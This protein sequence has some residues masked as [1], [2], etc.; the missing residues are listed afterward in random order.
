MLKE[1]KNIG[2]LEVGID[3]VGRGCLA[4]PV[5][6]GAVILPN[7]FNHKLIR[8]S[9]ALS[10]KQRDEAYELIIKNAIAYSVQASSVKIIDKTN[11]TEATFIAM[12]KCLDDLILTQG[13]DIKH[14]LVDGIV[15]NPYKNI[16]YSCIVKGDNTY[17]SIAAAAIIAKVE[18][19]NYMKKLH[20]IHPTYDF[21]S[22][23]GYGTATHIK[24]IKEHGL[25]Q[26]H[27]KLF[28]RNFI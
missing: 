3:E 18:R 17:T 8:D 7:D 10:E 23:K 20:E 5:V 13:Q 22:N 15:F 28:V 25:I 12:H 1:Y 24:S 11:I 27:R 14:I 19:D 4:G 21:F 16:P 2:V 26:A 6:T 9:K